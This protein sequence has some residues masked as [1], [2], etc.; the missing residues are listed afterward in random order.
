[1]R[2]MIYR[3]YG[4][5]S[6]LEAADL[7]RPTPGP[8]EILVRVAAS[9]VNPID[10]KLASGKLKYIQPLQLPKIA[11]FDLAGEVVEL[12]PGVQD[13]AI[14][15]RVHARLGG[16]TGGASAEYAVVGLDVAAPVP[17]GMDLGEA[18]AL[19]LA[20]M[21]ALQGL[22]DSAGLPM[23]GTNARVL[24]V[25]ASGGVGHFAV[26]IARNMGATVVG[27]CSGRNVALVASLGAHEV[28][29]YTKPDPYAG[30]APFDVVFDCVGYDYGSWLPRLTPTGRYVS[31]LP[32][33]G[34]MLRSFFNPFTARKV[35][36]LLL[37]S[38][39]ADLRVLDTMVAAGTLK[40]VV[41]S[42]FRLEALAAAWERSIG[43][44]AVGK[45]VVEI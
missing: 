10:W 9:S 29:D 17:P 26:Q 32:M 37:K 41:D 15:D 8:K 30:Q 19:P 16:L 33:P 43:G 45:I 36:P 40:V 12:G 42:R 38:R 44:R 20:G 5:P 7:P 24:I 27:V 22:R 23:T 2:T 13:F 28:I 14:G 39:A 11:G 35:H 18:A 1:M 25:G 6:G 31:P 21:T 3:A 4:P 34:M